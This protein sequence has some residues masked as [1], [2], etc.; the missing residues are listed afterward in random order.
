LQGD[1]E[2]L[3]GSGESAY[4]EALQVAARGHLDLRV[5]DLMI[6]LALDI[7]MIQGRFVE[8]LAQRPLVEA[9][10]TRAGDP[11]YQR[12]KFLYAFGM[13]ERRKGDLAAS[14]KLLEQSATVFASL[15]DE[16]LFLGDTLNQLAIT[17]FM[18]GDPKAAQA[19]WEQVIAVYERAISPQN[20]R[21]ATIRSNLA[22]VLAYEGKLDEAR[23]TF[24]NVLAIFE[25]VEG[26]DGPDVS[27]SRESLGEVELMAG[28][29]TAA[30]EHFERALAAQAHTP[31]AE[32]LANT[33]TFLAET[34]R[35]QG[36]LV[37]AERAARATLAEVEKALGAQSGAVATSLRVLAHIVLDA[38]RP[39]EA[40]PLV[41][42]AL[43]I[44]SP[45]EQRAD[46]LLVRAEVL[47]KMGRREAAIADASTAVKLFDK[48]GFDV[49]LTAARAT[50]ARA[51]DAVPR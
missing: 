32:T 4:N 46:S 45:D 9:A 5:L 19:R 41:E 34:L 48:P 23:A 17:L 12:A 35:R 50:L 25:S 33:R 39:R 22:V 13:V 30:R 49:K 21:V 24:T 11:P 20:P 2:A 43:A 51:R 37:D 18:Q 36:H 26:K 42:R 7:G 40:L 31:D 10:L 44:A 29:L 3:L 8:A 1:I 16:D 38:G 27:G 15:P 47:A 14:A 28:N 6:R